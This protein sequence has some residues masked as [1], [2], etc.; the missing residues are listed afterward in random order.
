MECHSLPK[1]PKHV[2]LILSDLCNQDCSF[3]AYRMEGYTSQQMF[4]EP[5]ARGRINP[6]RMIPWHK[7]MEIFDDCATMGVEAL[8]FTGG[9]E[10]T[11]HPDHAAIFEEAISRGF[12][13]ALVTNGYML[14][15][16]VI[17]Q[18]VH[19]SWVRISLDAGTSQTYSKIR[20]VPDGS[21]M[22]VL[23]NI[24]KLV[25]SR[26]AISSCC[27]IGVGFVVTPDNWVEVLDAA[28]LAKA[29]GVDNFRISAM[30]SPDDAGPFEGFFAECAGLC[31]AAEGLTTDTF[32]VYN[33]F[34]ERVEDLHQHGPDYEFCGYQHFTTY[35]G[36]DLNVYRCCN[37][38]YNERGLL[39]SLKEVG[40][41]DLWDSNPAE[42]FDAR[43]CERCQFNGIN[44]FINYARAHRPKHVSFV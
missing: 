22:R 25:K 42:P 23:K 20:R 9:G 12:Q 11:V 31:R 3:C 38:A 18:L 26:D 39:G 7:V 2:Q 8:Q 17:K 29:N 28:R 35:I 40:F 15:P 10:P 6:K 43:G 32:K 24:A 1:Y 27:E 37:T 30:F 4:G 16:D 14:K 33:R 36:G 41:K 44:R 5:D 34:G 13:I 21:F 19:A